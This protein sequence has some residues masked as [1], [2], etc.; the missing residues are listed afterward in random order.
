VAKIRTEIPIVT[1]TYTGSPIAKTMSFSTPNWFQG[2]TQGG[3]ALYFEVNGYNTD[4]STR[5]AYL[6]NGVGTTVASA[7]IVGTT[8][9]RIRVAA[10]SNV[11]LD[12]WSV[13]LS[14]T[15]GSLV[16]TIA[17]LIMI[18]N[19]GEYPLLY[20]MSFASIG[21]NASTMSSAAVVPANPRYWKYTASSWDGDLTQGFLIYM[22]ENAKADF[23]LYMY[24]TLG[25]SVGMFTIIGTGLVISSNITSGFP[26]TDGTIHVPRIATG[27]TMYATK[28]Y[29]L[30]VGTLQVTK[31][32]SKNF[33]FFQTNNNYSIYGPGGTYEAIAQK[34]STT[35]AT[36][37]QYVVFRVSRFGTTT[38]GL[39]VQLIE[40]AG[41][42]GTVLAISETVSGLDISTDLAYQ[43]Y[44]IFRFSSAIS[45]SAS[46]DYTVLLERTGAYSD[47]DFYRIPYS[48]SGV[49]SWL[50]SG[51]SWSSSGVN[52]VHIFG[53]SGITK[54][55]SQYYID[56][57]IPYGLSTRFVEYEQS[58][59]DGFTLSPYHSHDAPSSGFSTSKLVD[60]TADPD[61]DIAN[62]SLSGNGHVIASNSF[63]FPADGHEMVTNN[64]YTGTTLH[65]SRVIVKAVRTM[66]SQTEKALSA[67]S[68]CAGNF[69]RQT[70]KKVTS[71]SHAASSHLKKDFRS[72]FAISRLAGSTTKMSFIFLLNQLI[73]LPALEKLKVVFRDINTFVQGSVTKSSITIKRTTVW[74]NIS[75][76][77]NRSIQSFKNGAI[78]VVTG[79]Y[80][81]TDRIVAI[82]TDM[83]NQLL[84]TE[85]KWLISGL[86]LGT[87]LTKQNFKRL[88]TSLRYGISMIQSV[89]KTLIKS[90]YV[91]S[92]LIYDHIQGIIQKE[93]IALVRNAAFVSRESLKVLS[94]VPFLMSQIA[95]RSS[96]ALNGSTSQYGDLIGYVTRSLING[97][98]STGHKVKDI[99]R[100]FKYSLL[101]SSII[102]RI[103]VTLKTLSSAISNLTTL[104]KSM[105]RELVSV[106]WITTI[107]SLQISRWLVSAVSI[108]SSNLKETKNQ[109]GSNAA[110]FSILDRMKVFLKQLASVINIAFGIRKS[111]IIVIL[112]TSKTMSERCLLTVRTTISSIH[113]LSQQVRSSYNR[114]TSSVVI[115][116]LM[117]RVKVILISVVASLRN[118]SSIRRLIRKPVQQFLV[119][120]SW[121]RQTTS[122]QFASISQTVSNLKALISFE[123]RSDLIAISTTIKMSFL[124]FIQFLVTA[125]TGFSAWKVV[126]TVYLLALSTISHVVGRTNLSIRKALS[127]YTRI[128]GAKFHARSTASKS[129]RTLL[130]SIT[131]RHINLEIRSQ[132]G[133]IIT[134]AYTGDTIRLYGRFYNW[135][136]ELSDV[137]D[138]GI[139]IFD[140]KGNQ[141]I[142]DV[143][144]RQ[145]VGIYF[146]DYTIPTGF[147][148]PLVYEIS[149]IMEGTPLLARLTID[150]RWV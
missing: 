84:K 141:V 1:Y 19:V 39:R 91:S 58:D 117:V 69:I 95:R 143:P 125:T 65:G 50:K 63:T 144:T 128:L 68:S 142:Q 130:L 47:T 71:L 33:S 26:L 107:R 21:T 127:H 80:R 70:G 10:S 116:G 134:M 85:L 30:I 136:G 59:W 126:H 34:F 113:V 97:V 4:T 2:F 123:I 18:Q 16:L 82:F 109:L 147:S 29:S 64:T 106:N 54:F 119:V 112:A 52:F 102:T 73:S 87:I 137:T 96:K 101:I 44:V 78:H 28:L 60:V 20:L 76:S 24:N 79:L 93:V 105:L 57:E 99:F 138:P 121:L 8:P 77:R 35:T 62:T 27:N 61:T 86:D 53:P 43:Q 111:V 115:L 7:S 146:F 48:G 145:Q 118:S 56:Q 89:V 25:S 81:H 11:M 148:D 38:D 12:Q 114:L 122:K 22:I 108:T 135:S 41:T 45:L 88:N 31:A 104:R 51:G 49:S 103:R 98:V 120:S 23:Y 36:T 9:Q 17:K 3:L 5:Y 110:V 46:S 90:L 83:T 32:L 74:I 150:R 140:G 55:E 129:S 75:I 40:G 72:L 14:D 100:H 92:S 124:D 6:K 149:G 37:I 133:N 13:E 67:L 139:I 42:T 15:S 132:E 94:E 66:G 131:E